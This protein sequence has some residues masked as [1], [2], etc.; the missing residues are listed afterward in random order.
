MASLYTYIWI[1]DNIYIYILYE[2]QNAHDLYVT[3][4]PLSS[5]KFLQLTMIEGFKKTDHG[6]KGWQ[7]NFHASLVG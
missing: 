4:I 1:Y 3:M 6:S 5:Y 2:L 7:K